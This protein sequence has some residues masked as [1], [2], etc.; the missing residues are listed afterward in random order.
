MMAEH[1]C[2]RTWPENAWPTPEQL[3]EYVASCCA[4]CRL[5]FAA[6]AIF[7]AM[8][9]TKCIESNHR[10]LVTEVAVRGE[11][12]AVWKARSEELA[13]E[14]AHV[15][16]VVESIQER[17]DNLLTVSDRFDHPG[18]SKHLARRARDKA[19]GLETALRLLIPP[20]SADAAAP[21]GGD[22]S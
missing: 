13:D 14:S 21:Q 16:R 5:S 10:A 3:A 20:T 7:S 12:T 19:A 1:T 8:R 6:G 17:I 2:P 11:Q 22:P 15:V 4:Q 18:G 9:A